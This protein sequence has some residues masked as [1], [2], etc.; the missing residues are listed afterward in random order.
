MLLE[1]RGVAHERR[2]LAEQRLEKLG[3]GLRGATR[4]LD[5]HHRRLA[6]DR[7]GDRLDGALAARKDEEDL[8]DAHLGPK[9]DLAAEGRA[10][11]V[12]VDEQKVRVVR[13][14]PRLD[15]RVAAH[16]LPPGVDAA[17]GLAGLVKALLVHHCTVRCN[18]D[19]RHP[20]TVCGRVH[21]DCFADKRHHSCVCP[22]GDD[23]SVG[24]S[25]SLC[26]PALEEKLKVWLQLHLLRR[27][28]DRE[29]HRRSAELPACSEQ[30]RGRLHIRVVSKAGELGD[31]GS[32]A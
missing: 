27:A 29:Q 22:P 4:L 30:P 32:S 26:E 21:G 18:A 20:L 12:V 13:I 11:L 31:W 5:E 23:P 9:F 28:R 24:G 19:A 17:A 8:G 2:A 14:E 1:H 25:R 16:L 10:L 6:L 15:T 7:L 3:D